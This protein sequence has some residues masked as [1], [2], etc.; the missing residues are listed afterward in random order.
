MVS[1]FGKTGSGIQGDLDGNGTV[2]IF[3]YNT[4]VGNFGK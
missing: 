1:N 3:D 2:N 4:L